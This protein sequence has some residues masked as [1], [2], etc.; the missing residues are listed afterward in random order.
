MCTTPSEEM[1]VEDGMSAENNS[2]FSKQ[3]LSGL[4]FSPK[5]DLSGLTF[6]PYLCGKN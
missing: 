6:F 2:S 4:T 5:R 3:P 1:A